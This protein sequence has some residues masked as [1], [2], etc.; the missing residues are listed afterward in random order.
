MERVLCGESEFA[1]EPIEVAQERRMRVA[2]K[3]SFSS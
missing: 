3:L 1:T 2:D